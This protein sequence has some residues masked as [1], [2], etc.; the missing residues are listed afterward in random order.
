MQ[1]AARVI[2]PCLALRAF[3]GPRPT[4]Q[5]KV[6]KVHQPTN[7][8]GCM[9]VGQAKGNAWERV[10]DPPNRN[11]G[12]KRHNTLGSAT[13]S[14]ALGEGNATPLQVAATQTDCLRQGSTPTNRQLSTSRNIVMLAQNKM[15][16]QGMAT[17]RKY[18]WQKNMLGRRWVIFSL[19]SKLKRNGQSF[20]TCTSLN[21]HV[22]RNSF[23]ISQ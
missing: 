16:N 7:A 14:I 8:K 19:R 17:A 13:Y 10:G 12:G 20:V 5:S 1:T 4:K 21:S 18:R 11:K 22:M 2:D 9:A 15:S 3:A 6:R 23:I